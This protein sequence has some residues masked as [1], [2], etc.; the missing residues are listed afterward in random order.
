MTS[1]AYKIAGGDFERGG[2]ASRGLKE[3][4][5][6]LGAD[7]AVVRRAMIAAYEAEMNV[8]I[9]AYRGELRA[10][11]DNGQLEVE[12]ADEGPGIPDPAAA[13]REGWSTA[14]AQARELGFGA[15]MGLPNIKKNSD[16]FALETEV[17][18]GTRIRFKIALR[19][20]ALYGA[21]RHSLQI[22]AGRCQQ[23]FRC[24][25]A[26]PTAAMRVF[27]GKPEVLDYLCIDCTACIADCPSGT[28][29]TCGTRGDLGPPDDVVL[30]VPAAALVQFG[31]AIAPQRVLAELAAIGFSD[32][33]ITADW[34]AALLAAAVAGAQ[35]SDQPRPVISPGC[36]AVVNLIESRF[37]ALLPNLAPYC[38]ATDALRAA[39]AGRRALFVITC[40]SQRTALAAGPQPPETVLPVALRTALAPRLAEKPEGAPPQPVLPPAA[41]AAA[42]HVLQVTGIRH[43]LRVLEEIE[44]GA[45]DDVAVLDAWSCDGGCFGSPLLAQDPHLARQRWQAAGLDVAG[46]RAVPRTQPYTPRRGLR[47]DN[48][49]TRAVQKLARIDKLKRT[50]PGSDCGQCGAPTCAALAED[51]VLGRAAAD[52]C[53]RQRGT[54]SPENRP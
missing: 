13:M 38:S 9:H 39:L 23:S 33:R 2:A 22:D 50:L 10:T 44:N 45:V 5:K 19:P 18:R 4:L 3:Q 20:Q 26:C 11:V 17:G 32:V 37:P 46:G 29:H 36:P 21:G 6:K 42:P 15:G 24:V 54:P 35:R 28:L 49:M 34:D 30:V 40:P 43:V 31:A 1:A 53:V 16:A 41:P 27:R 51:I 52:A 48:D 7:P 14:S 47:L 25:A 8:V 12:V